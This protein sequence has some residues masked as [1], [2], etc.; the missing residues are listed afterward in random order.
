MSKELKNGIKIL[1]GPAFFKLW[2]KIIK[3]LFWS[4]TQE[5]L[6]SLSFFSLIQFY[7]YE[8]HRLLLALN[9]NL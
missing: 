8:K 7:V 4:I 9:A 2:I 3:I 5:T 1:V 6:G